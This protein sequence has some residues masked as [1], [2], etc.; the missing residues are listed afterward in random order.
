LISG[1]KTGCPFQD[2]IYSAE[3]LEAH[4][5]IPGAE[6]QGVVVLAPLA[7]QFDEGLRRSQA[8]EGVVGMGEVFRKEHPV[9]FRVDLLGY[10]EHVQE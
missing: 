2:R 1:F 3:I 9:C 4:V 8:L 10:L 6:M 7:G 5:R